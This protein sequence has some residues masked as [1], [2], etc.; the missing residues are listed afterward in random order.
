VIEEKDVDVI[1]LF[2][3]VVLIADGFILLASQFRSQSWALQVCAATI[4][5][6][7][8]PAGLVVAGVIFAGIFIV[9]R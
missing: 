3:L 1:G 6:C 2:L 9:Q 5:L 4:N 7:D 8:H